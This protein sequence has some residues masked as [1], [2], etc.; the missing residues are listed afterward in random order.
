MTRGRL[1]ELY[2]S[3]FYE[4]YTRKLLID[5]CK[6]TNIFVCNDIDF[7]NEVIIPQS[8]VTL[9]DRLKKER[10]DALLLMT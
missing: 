4:S 5:N 8:N 10:N 7:K 1:N 2:T 6:N 3:R 9:W